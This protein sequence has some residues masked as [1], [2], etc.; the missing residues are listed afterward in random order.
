MSNVT[1]D[2]PLPKAGTPIIFGQHRTIPWE[3]HGGKTGTCLNGYVRVPGCLVIDPRSLSIHGG[4][5]WEYGRWI[6]FHTFHGDEVWD[7]AE[8]RSLGVTPN[9]KVLAM[10][11]YIDARLGACGRNPLTPTVPWNLEKVRA[12]TIALADQVAD[13]LEP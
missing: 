5:D 8:L 3:I 1:K 11:T 6:G 4:I 10:T 9:R 13:R 7:E 12:E 2:R